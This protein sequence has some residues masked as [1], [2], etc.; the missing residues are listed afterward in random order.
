MDYLKPTNEHRILFSQH[1]LSAYSKSF[2]YIYS[3]SLSISFQ[4]IAI[5]VH[6]SSNL[7]QTKFWPMS[8]GY[9][10]GDKLN[11]TAIQ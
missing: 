6:L 3:Y 7:V 2:I 10:L 8:A 1:D 5:F 4:M 9:E 11:L